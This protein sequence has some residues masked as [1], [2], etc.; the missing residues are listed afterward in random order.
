MID[1]RAKWGS[2]HYR[3]VKL[4]CNAANFCGQMKVQARHWGLHETDCLMSETAPVV[5]IPG[6]FVSLQYPLPHLA[7]ALVGEAPVR[8][9]AI[10]S[11]STA[12]RADVVPYPHRL[13]M[14]LRARFGDEQ[15]PN[16]RIDVLNRGRGGEEA[17]EELRRFSADI[18]AEKPSL[19]I[20]QV[21]TNAVFH[22]YNL[23]Q[24]AASIAEGLQ[25]MSVEPMDV[26]LIDPQY[27]PAMLFDDKA[28]ASER[29]V[30]LISA[31]ADRAK[32]NMF[33]RWALMRHWHVHN[34]IGLDQFFDPTDPD[35]LHQSDWSTFLVAKALSVAI[36]RASPVGV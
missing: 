36:A 17:I 28:E 29:M 22:D 9:V 13:E 30:S 33:R 26:L 19:A 4:I 25:R 12:G 2:P 20:W 6:E 21:G 35:K 11:S 34:D 7:K 24:V 5:D 27:T 10:G 8:I 23:D 14:Y 18:F 15:F 16:L 1:L 31:A 3:Q 32:V